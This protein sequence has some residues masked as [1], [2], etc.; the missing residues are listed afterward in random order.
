MKEDR[1]DFK[2]DFLFL[3][4]DEVEEDHEYRGG[5]GKRHYFWFPVGEILNITKSNEVN[6]YL[7]K[8]K[9]NSLE[10]E[11]QALFANDALFNLFEA[12]HMKET[13]S[14]YLEERREL[15]KVL[16][17]FIRVNSGGTPFRYSDHLLSFA[18]AQWE[19]LDAKEKI[20]GAVD[21]L[22]DVGRGFNITK[23]LLLKASLVLCEF[24]DIRF[25]ADNFNRT[26]MLIIEK[27][28]DNITASMR[29]A[30]ELVASFG[31]CRENI[32]SNNALIPIAYYISVIGNSTNFVDSGKYTEDRKNQKV[33]CIIHFTSCIQYCI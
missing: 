7:I 21:K 1:A 22:N 25:K 5:D 31:F 2:Y 11:E 27:K 32:T 16:N 17:I 33:V 29:L 13:I 4:D 23:D 8:N 19:K 20:N 12:I 9:L 15:D 14:Y 3:T 10:D 24:P 18:M 30:L 26:N 28:W 6:K